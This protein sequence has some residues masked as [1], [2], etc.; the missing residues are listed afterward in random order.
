[1]ELVTPGLGLII[2]MTVAFSIVLIILRKY[3]WQP[4][5]LAIKEREDAISQSLRD[6]KYV[7]NEMLELEKKK[8]DKLEEA[9]KEYQLILSNAKAEGDEI[10]KN[11]NQKALD[12]AKLMLNNA[13]KAIEQ[14]KKEAFNEVKAQIA[15]LS[16]DMAGKVLEERFA[17]SDKHE[18]FINDMLDKINPN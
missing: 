8:Q 17:D 6:A 13:H 18:A 9:Q 7:R 12:E 15:I 5:L 3:A 2:W 4:I 11:A 1:M 14:E 10:I 16:I